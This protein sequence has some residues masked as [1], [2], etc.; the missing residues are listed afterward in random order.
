MSPQ[1]QAAYNAWQASQAAN[2]SPAAQGNMQWA[3]SAAAA[4]AITQQQAY[5]INSFRGQIY[6][7]DQLDVQDTPLYDTITKTAG[8]SISNADQWWAN[9]NGSGKS[10]AQT[11]MTNNKV[12]EAPEAFAVFS[13][14]VGW[15]E[16]MLRSDLTALLNGSAYQLWLGK[17]AY[18]V[19]NIRN[20]PPGSGI[21]G[22]SSRTAESV[23]THGFPSKGSLQLIDVKI[24]IANQMSFYAYLDGFSTGSQTFSANGV[25]A[26]LINQF[27]GLYARGVQ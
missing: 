17:K 8:Q 16:D 4:G 21:A 20:F 3:A 27:G 14:Q 7:S 1:Q 6:I 11:N 2:M 23:Y 15:S 18:Q 19:R 9:I 13:V 12:L 22:F 10:I 26:I 24:V 25:G 5:I